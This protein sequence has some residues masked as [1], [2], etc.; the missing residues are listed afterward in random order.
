MHMNS[1][2]QAGRRIG[3]IHPGLKRPG[4]LVR[5]YKLSVDW[6]NPEPDSPE[7]SASF[8][9]DYDLSCNK[10]NPREIRMLLRFSLGPNQEEGSP[11]C[12]YNIY[13]EIEGF[14]TFSEDLGDDQMGY[15]C[16]VNSATILYGILRGEIGNVTGSFRGGKFLLPTVM[17]Q[18]VVNQVEADKAEA[19]ESAALTSGE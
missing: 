8:G 12:S 9:F 13:A 17:M 11:T 10:D 14:F 19:A 5:C 15:L 2:L 1:S 3:T 16:R 7:E 6:L 4:F 18:D